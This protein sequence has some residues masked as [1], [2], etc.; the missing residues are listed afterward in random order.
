MRL[1][2]RVP[3][4]GFAQTN[5]PNNGHFDFRKSFAFRTVPETGESSGLYL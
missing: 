5:F 1:L 2:D 4:I 3:R